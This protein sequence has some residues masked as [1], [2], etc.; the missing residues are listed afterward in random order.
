MNRY[1]SEVAEMDRRRR[2]VVRGLSFVGAALLI[3]AA[4]R[5]LRAHDAGGSAGLHKIQVAREAV[6]EGED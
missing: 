5:Q 1:Q 2:L 4:L 6:L 3:M